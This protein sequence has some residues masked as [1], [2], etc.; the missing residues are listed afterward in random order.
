MS[1]WILQFL[2]LIL[3]VISQPLRNELVNF[4]KKFQEDARETANPWDDFVADILCWL[5]QVP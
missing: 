4:A 5:F 3:T 1:K 2:P